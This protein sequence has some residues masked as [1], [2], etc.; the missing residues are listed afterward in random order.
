[1]DN[2]VMVEADA[3]AVATELLWTTSV[4]PFVG[5]MLGHP[6]S[7]TETNTAMA[8]HKITVFMITTSVIEYPMTG[9]TSPVD[10]MLQLLAMNINDCAFL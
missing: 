10:T 6:D 8:R 1:M 5:K 4:F 3:V 2:V 7:V 9:S